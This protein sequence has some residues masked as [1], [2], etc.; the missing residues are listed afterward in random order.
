MR[1]LSRVR[2]FLPLPLV[3][4]GQ[5]WGY[6]RGRFLGWSHVRMCHPASVGDPLNSRSTFRLVRIRNVNFR[7]WNAAFFRAFKCDKRTA[8]DR[9]PG[10]AN[11]GAARS[12]IEIDIGCAAA[13]IDE[14]SPSGTRDINVFAETVVLVFRPSTDLV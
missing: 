7:E 10:F 6:P 2:H 8:V 9:L 1:S 14:L 12:A 13:T 3:G 5:G 11:D 4:R